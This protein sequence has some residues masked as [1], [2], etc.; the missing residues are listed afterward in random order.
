[1]K[2]KHKKDMSLFF[3]LHPALILIYADLNNYAYEQHGIQLTITST[4]STPQQ[5]AQLGRISTSHLT[6]RAIDIRTKDIDVFA[7]QDM[8]NYINSKKEYE[9]YH[10]ISFS[11]DKRLAYVHGDGDNEHLHLQI[12]A[13]YALPQLENTYIARAKS[14]LKS[15]F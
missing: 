10:Y 3:S 8:L 14:Y 6:R 11:G 1:M 7:V 15:L 2:F 12:H 4:V 13:N 9:K 5:D